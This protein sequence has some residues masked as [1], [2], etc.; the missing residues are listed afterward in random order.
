MKL[1]ATWPRRLA[2][3]LV[4]LVL[5]QLALA[6]A[7]YRDLA[8]PPAQPMEPIAGV[9]G[10]SAELCRTCHASIYD[11]WAQS[12][13][14]RAFVDPLYQAE[15][16]HAEPTYPCERCHTPLVEQ[17][18]TRVL[19]LA[20]VWPSF[21]PFSLGNDRF[22]PVLQR[23]GVTCV[24]CHVVDA[25]IVGPFA[26]PRD[27]PHPTQRVDLRDPALCARCHQLDFEVVGRKL[28][29]PILDTVAEWRGLAAHGRDERCVD[30][31]MP[32]VDPRP[33]ARTGEPRP[34]T[35]HRL[36]GPFDATFVAER[37]R[38]ADVELDGAR[39]RGAKTRLVLVNDS[40]HRVPTAEPERHVVVQLAAL[41]A[42]DTVLATATERIERRVDVAKLREL[43]VDTTLAVA[44]Q[45][46]LALELPAPLP[47]QA[48]A[49]A[50]TVDFVLWDPSAAVLAELP[51]S[52]P[53]SH[54]L[55]ER[56]LTLAEVP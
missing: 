29:R 47:A 3:V 43:G 28:E 45:R 46:P 23:E 49:L 12:G 10:V 11:E 18:P 7:I 55:L 40:G 48:V 5:A 22:D 15:L 19:G 24:A 17:R 4:V 30:C 26:D 9:G 42:D 14:A 52:Q 27:A 54:R 53:A 44:E 2:C 51:T 33:A 50:L 37:V 41:A 39:D 6:H 56:R 32:T 35:S 16:A 36:P 1:L 25:S 34:G 13:H 38:V 8:P 21:V 31:H 20:L